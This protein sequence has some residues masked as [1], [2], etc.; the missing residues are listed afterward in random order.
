MFQIAAGVADP[1]IV[2]GG[3]N[4]VTI[5]GA[6]PGHIEAGI[7]WAVTAGLILVGLVIGV[8]VIKFLIGRGAEG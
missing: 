8:L 2:Q 4:A 1:N 5:V 3:A 6:V 7:N